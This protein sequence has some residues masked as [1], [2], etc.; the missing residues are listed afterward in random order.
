M[1]FRKKQYKIIIMDRLS[2]EQRH[3]N[4]AAIHSK[5]TKPEILVRKFLFSRGFRYRLNYP[6]LPGKPDIVLRKYKT[7]IFIN[8]CFWHGHDGCKYFV[9]PKTRTEFWQAKIERNKERDSENKRQLTSMGWHC[10]TIWECQLKP[11]VRELTLE[12]LSY[13]LSLILLKNYKVKKYDLHEKDSLIVAE[14]T[15]IYGKG[16][17]NKAI[18]L[19]KNKNKT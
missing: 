9:M 14:A 5:D 1:Q 11:K 6:L 7:C 18:E 16:N 13:T 4:M 12:S 17:I 10:I 19:N 3:R 15:D 2:R 8:G